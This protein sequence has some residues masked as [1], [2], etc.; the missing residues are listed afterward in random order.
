MGNKFYLYRGTRCAVLL[1]PICQVVGA[2]LNGIT[3]SVNDLNES[4][5]ACVEQQ[6][7][8][9]YENWNSVEEVN[10]LSYDSVQLQWFFEQVSWPTCFER[11]GEKAGPRHL[12]YRYELFGNDFVDENDG[13]QRKTEDFD[14]EDAQTFAL[15]ADEER[16][17]CRSILS[18]GTSGRRFAEA[19]GSGASVG[20]PPKGF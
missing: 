19:K 7:L 20:T 13:A 8:E 9:A 1:N 10:G 11:E 6:V 4:H 15:P 12:D 17:A 16:Q 14:V 5:K 18:A 2:I 3:Y